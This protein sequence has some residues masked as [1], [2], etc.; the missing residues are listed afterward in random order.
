M[1]DEKL[2]NLTEKKTSQ[3]YCYIIKSIN[4]L[5]AN[6]TYNGYT[7]N[8]KKRLREHN[9]DIKGGARAT[10]G[11]GPWVYI[12][13]WTGYQTR[14]EALSCEWR[15]KHPTNKKFRGSKYNGVVGRIK[16]LN[17][18]IGLDFWTNKSIGMNSG[19]KYVLYVDEN[20]IDLINV[21]IKKSNLMIEK[22]NVILEKLI[23]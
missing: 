9:G 22:L 8:L 5:F 19:T 16:S 12:V 2:P 7:N 23:Y 10:R 1:I 4:P 13:I 18:L 3:Y 21:E 15:I 20:Y 11:K 14:N 17:L 6:S